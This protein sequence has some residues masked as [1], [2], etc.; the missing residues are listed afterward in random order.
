MNEKILF[1]K[2]DKALDD[3]SK[4]FTTVIQEVSALDFSLYAKEDIYSAKLVTAYNKYGYAIGIQV[5]VTYYD[6]TIDYL[7]KGEE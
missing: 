3:D 2:F 5:I 1:E 4:E 7:T 6:G